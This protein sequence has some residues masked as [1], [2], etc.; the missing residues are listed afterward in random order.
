MLEFGLPTSDISDQNTPEQNAPLIW[1][2][3]KALIDHRLKC[4]TENYV[5]EGDVLLPRFL[6]ESSDNPSVKT[7]FVGFS[8]IREA[9]K[10]ANMREFCSK[11]DWTARFSDKKTLELIKWL[12]KE[13]KKYKKSC[14]KYAIEYF[15][16]SD[17]FIDVI[18]QITIYLTM[19]N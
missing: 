13:S 1:P 16:T 8:E 18:N 5:I 6:K 15:D 19:S 3:I 12:Q 7:C 17:N 11:T 9:D 4:C 2:Y 10:L 14:L